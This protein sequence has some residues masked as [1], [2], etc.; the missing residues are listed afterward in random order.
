[1][2]L[3]A[4][5]LR[6]PPAE[7]AALEKEPAGLRALPLDAALA[8]GRALDLGRAWEELGCLLEGGIRIP[9]TGPTVGY[10]PL[11]TTEDGAAWAG[12]DADRVRRVADELGVLH[13]DAFIRLYVVDD[14]ETADTMPGERTGEWGDRAQYLYGK[15]ELLRTHYV[16]AARL[17]QAL[18]VRIAA[19]GPARR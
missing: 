7:L 8:D 12:V 15:L 11:G 18:L 9:E 6:L 16:E 4:V 13:R 19:R 2:I 17:G 10:R 1:M 5:Y 14:G 3:N